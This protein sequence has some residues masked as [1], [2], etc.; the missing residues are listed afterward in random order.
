[1]KKYTALFVSWAVRA[2]L[3]FRYRITYKGLENLTEETL[4]KPGGILF[5]PNH[6][7]VFVD[8]ASVAIGVWSKF[9]LRPMIVD[10]FYYQPIVNPI[11]R[12]M[13]AIPVPDFEG[14]SNSLKRK[15]ND[16]V[17]NT[18]INDLRNG[19][20]FLIYPAGTTKKTAK[21]TI[22]G[23]SG[24]H[25]IIQEVPEANIVL[26]RT[27]GLWGSSFSRAVTGGSPP[28]MPTIFAGLKY[29][30]KNLIFFTPRRKVIVEYIPAPAD[31]PYKA[32]RLEMNRWL[33]RWYNQPDGLTEQEGDEPGDSLVQVSFSMWSY[34][35]PEIY[36]PEKEDT[37]AFSLDSIDEE[38]KAKVT[39]E[40]AKIT[41]LDPEKIT[42]KSHL[43]IDLG[44]D[45]LDISDLVA[46]V[47]D[48]YGIK[49]IAVSEMTTVGKVM[50]IAD[51]KVTLKEE[52][53]SEAAID[54]EKWHQPIVRE[55]KQIAPGNTIAEVF[56]NNCQRMGNAPACA[57]VRSG[58]LTY[59]E[60]KLRSL[61]LAEK[62]RHMPGEYIGI[63]LPSTVAAYVTAIAALIAGKI[64]L[65]VNWT[66][67]PRHL[68]A[69]VK[70]SHVEVILTSWSFLDRL[71]GV[72]LDVIEDKLVMLEDLRR[73]FS[74]K[75]KLQAYWRSKLRTE[76]LL[77][78]FN[79]HKIS[80]DSRAVLLFTS[81]TESLPKG[82]PL[83]HRNILSNQ[84]SSCNSVDFYSDDVMIGMLP[85]FHAF[86]F[87]ASGL[88]ALLAGTRA[89]YFPDP[90]DGKK[91]AE[92][93]K[94]WGGT[95]VCG[96]PTFLKSMFRSGTQEDFATIRLC[97]TGAEKAPPEL[98]QL[99][100]SLGICEE[101]LLEGYGITECSPV[102]TMNRPGKKASGVGEPL[103]G[104]ELKI[105]HPE[106]F[107]AMG[108]QE[109]G[110]VL[111][112]GPNVFAGYLNTDVASPFV[113]IDG[114]QWYKTGDLGYLD[115]GG[116][117]IICGRQKRFIKVAGEMIS[118][119]SLEDALL[120]MAVKKQWSVNDEGPT[121][122]I[123]ATEKPGEK[124]KI[125]LFTKEA[126]EL[127]E[128][129]SALRQAGFSNL[130]KVTSVTQLE[131]I[132]IMGTGKI[133]YRALEDEYMV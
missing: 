66:V 41:E 38:V 110:L 59:K 53:V 10:Y 78:I 30:F 97:V 102:L 124:P 130:V 56:L 29:A 111:A 60:L 39:A 87:T 21:E 120:E 47:Q 9:S 103:E 83:S 125:A 73:K 119:T 26:V 89:V 76:S 108:D 37:S 71:T 118:L 28:L 32:S 94:K 4:N 50:A 104:V 58:V 16:K 18:L 25:R 86:G 11:M 107:E 62:I 115:E 92:T 49:N 121:L 128:V 46:Y 40:I 95:V 88:M 74:L 31:F 44:M 109:S 126:V 24:V 77:K 68:E 64:P 131:E 34:Q 91:L 22:G 122:A 52:K 116:R 55:K 114:E 27:K 43:S 101:K 127:D 45:S 54:F 63:M 42:P 99:A 61:L 72:D 65:M 57:D 123:C 20:N 3:W 14:S 106:T 23:A 117:L 19:E 80:K 90:T 13:D 35:V 113:T 85:P 36:H 17:L 7:S 2:I 1:M 8:P 79:I 6:P 5:L 12:L 96:A 75:D 100:A 112:R 15:L 33:E 84:R 98:Y 132:P 133:S 81:G 82:V 105:V 48:H 129:N 67:G 51:K 70:L 93:V 69:V